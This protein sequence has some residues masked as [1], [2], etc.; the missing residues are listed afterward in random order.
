VAENVGPDG[1]G[2]NPA[3]A[4]AGGGESE[5]QTT[6]GWPHAREGDAP[7]GA[8]NKAV[9]PARKPEWVRLLVRTFPV[10]E[11]AACRLVRCNR[12]T[13]LYRAHQRD[14]TAI[15]QR[16]LELA[17][18]RPRFGYARLPGLLRREGWMVNKKRVHRIYRE[19]GLAVRFT[20]RRKRASHLRV[21]PPLPHR[22]NER[23]SM[24][25]VA[26]TLLDGRRIRA[27]TVVDH[28][29]RHSP[30]IEVD[31]T[32]TG[33]KVVMALERVAKY[34][35]CPKMITVDNGGEFASRA[36]DVW[37]YRHGI[38][39]DFIRPG[40]PVENGFIERFNGRLR[41]ECL[42]VAVFFTLED[43]REKLARWR[44]D[45]N[46][47][48]PHSSLQDQTPASVAADWAVMAQRAHA[49]HEL[50]E[51]LT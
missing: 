41:D 38:Q 42:N 19:E 11:R 33:A 31:F 18:A 22:V 50:L 47:L 51:T 24:D 26:D 29:S 32:L 28:G 12:S 35:G 25:V 7:G 39:L 15:R 23:P 20:R 2:R 34:R 4:A 8:H 46:H 16:M 44:A 43:V 21:V 17:Q 10:S 3:L 14:D 1:D 36:M 37:A 40:K 13:W 48:R 5:I 49:S 27:L 45:D 30:F 9:K 6:G